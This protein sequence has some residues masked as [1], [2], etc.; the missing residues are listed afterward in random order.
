MLPDVLQNAQVVSF[1]ILRIALLA[2]QATSSTTTN[3]YPLAQST[4]MG[5]PQ[6]ENVF[7]AQHTVTAA[8]QAD[9]RLVRIPDTYTT[10]PAFFPA[11]LTPMR[12]ETQAII[13]ALT[14]MR[15]ALL[16]PAK[17]RIIAGSV[18]E[19]CSFIIINACPNVPLALT[20]REST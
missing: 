14:A 4:T 7:L 3:A 8:V 11:L 9:A 13:S 15:P 2:L 5:I 12:K 19:D 17:V 6:F 18:K 1:L 10:I 16:A 20:K